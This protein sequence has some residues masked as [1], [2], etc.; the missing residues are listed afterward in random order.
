MTMTGKFNVA[1]HACLPGPVDQVWEPFQ[2]A[3]FSEEMLP[4]CEGWMPVSAFPGKIVGR[5][6]IRDT[7][8]EMIAEKTGRET[9]Y[10]KAQKCNLMREGEV[11]AQS[12]WPVQSIAVIHTSSL[13]AI[14][15]E[16]STSK[17]RRN[18][19][20]AT[21]YGDGTP[22]KGPITISRKL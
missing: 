11:L 8:G 3:N 5:I 4:D 14:A 1:S 17:T 20:P 21:Q 2:A 10:S 13:A 16:L 15:D 19:T 6:A 12:D 18:R 9:P 22:P 7:L